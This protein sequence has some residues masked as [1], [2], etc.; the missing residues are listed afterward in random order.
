VTVV[1]AQLEL[2][3]LIFLHGPTSECAE[4]AE[5]RLSASGGTLR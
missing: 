2:D 5:A 3:P 4:C 1:R